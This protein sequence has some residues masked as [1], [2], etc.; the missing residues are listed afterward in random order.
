MCLLFSDKK[1]QYVGIP[2][3]LSLATIDMQFIFFAALFSLFYSNRILSS[4]P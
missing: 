2:N 4:V 3:F 1:K